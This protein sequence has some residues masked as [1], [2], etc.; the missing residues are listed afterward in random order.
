MGDPQSQPAGGYRIDY[1]KADATIKE[2]GTCAQELENQRVPGI[3]VQRLREAWT[4]ATGQAFADRIEEALRGIEEV[5]KDV[6]N[7]AGRIEE[8]KNR[9]Q[10]AERET[11]KP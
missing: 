3:L 5:G 4:D 2:I 8:V 7:L 6:D 1:D 9:Y 11:K 10:R